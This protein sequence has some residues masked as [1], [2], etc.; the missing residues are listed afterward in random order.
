MYVWIKL[1]NKVCHINSIIE[2]LTYLRS[3]QILIGKIPVWLLSECRTGYKNES[4]V[5]K[6]ENWLTLKLST[7]VDQIYYIFTKFLDS[8][9][10][11]IKHFQSGRPLTICS[12]HIH[13]FKKYE[14]ITN[15]L[16]RLLWFVASET[17]TQ[18]QPSSFCKAALLIQLLL[19]AW[20]FMQHFLL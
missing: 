6:L 16:K 4:H 2:T 13:N 3:L 20:Q 15:T 9:S 18:P 5:L 8:D 19:R 17:Q 1:D 12:M 7:I 14:R 10:C 11:L